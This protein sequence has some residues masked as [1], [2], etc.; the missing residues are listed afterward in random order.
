M[1]LIYNTQEDIAILIKDF[2]KKV[3][4]NIRKTQLKIIPYI[5]IGMILAESVVASD[6]SK[7]LKGDFSLVQHDS[8]IKRIRR[9]FK[10]KHFNPYQFYDGIIK[11][12]ISNYK[13]KHNDKRIHI[14]FD[15][16][17][18]HDNYT[19]FMITMRIGKQGIPLW[20]RCFKGKNDS[21]A[22]KELLLKEGISYIS[23]LFSDDYNLIFLA[24][25]WFN[26]TSLFEHINSLGHTY[27]IR[28][29]GIIKT[30]IYDSREK[31]EIWKTLDD[32]K[33]R[34]SKSKFF[35]NIKLSE[36]QYITNLVISKS[37]DVKE[38]WIIV[39]NGDPKRAIKDYGY[40]FGGVETLFKNQKSNG[41]YLEKTT[42]ASLKYFES[43]YSLS[44]ISVL[45]LTII[46][47]DYTKN[48]KSYKK[49]KITT[50]QNKKK[51]IVR[52]VLSLFNTGLTLFKR[53]YNSSL[54]IRLPIRF[55]LYDI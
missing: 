15:H 27:C 48:S 18:S 32:I 30:L 1:N 13:S 31:H 21:N 12:V 40:R 17:F 19:V 2:F 35:Y 24:D 9:F 10:N 53:A 3:F 38:P 29:K 20:F 42:K 25:R 44:C 4:P 34:T 41:F 26:S 45:L 16:M 55:I 47:A 11:Y 50:H 39:T 28:L 22:F 8:V 49:V 6:I 5:L 14:I 33:S 54:Y 46:G 36:K 51:T 52:R 37:K 7:E 43:M 23:S